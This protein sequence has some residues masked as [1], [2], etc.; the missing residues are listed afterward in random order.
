MIGFSSAT[1]NIMDAYSVIQERKNDVVAASIANKSGNKKRANATAIGAG[2]GA[3]NAV[4]LTSV[5]KVANVFSGLK[6]NILV[7][8]ICSQFDKWIGRAENF[9]PM[10]NKSM[11]RTLGILGKGMYGI[12]AGAVTGFALDIMN[13]YIKKQ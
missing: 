3:L 10:A 4:L 11:Q 8:W 5:Y 1:T 2:A 13:K 12:T 7:N 9:F 6:S